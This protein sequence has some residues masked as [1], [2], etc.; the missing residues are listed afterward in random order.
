[1][2]SISLDMH[3]P[4]ITRIYNILYNG[5]GVR[6]LEITFLSFVVILNMGE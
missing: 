2:F 4:G 1:M 5:S 6:Y 3:N